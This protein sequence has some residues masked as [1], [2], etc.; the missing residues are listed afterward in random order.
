MSAWPPSRRRLLVAA[1]AAVTTVLL[2]RAF[3]DGMLRTSRRAVPA[4][5][6]VVIDLNRA[7]VGELM[8]LP[9][10]GST[11]ADAIV[12]HRVRHGPFR[13]VD[14]LLQVDGIGP[15][16]VAALRRHVAAAATGG[17]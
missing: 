9:G 2:V 4:A 16:T 6:P 14:D 3:A 12:L 7:R 13:S 17:R 5:V 15:E 11:R 8:A 1:W 10:V